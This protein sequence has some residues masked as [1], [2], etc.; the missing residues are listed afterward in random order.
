MPTFQLERTS[1]FCYLHLRWDY[2]RCK[3]ISGFALIPSPSLN[4]TIAI[5]IKRQ[6]AF[7][8]H[9][10]QTICYQRWDCSGKGLVQERASVERASSKSSTES[11]NERLI[12]M[13]PNVCHF[14]VSFFA[15]PQVQKSSKTWLYIQ[16][17]ADHPDHSFFDRL[18]N[19]KD[20]FFFFWIVPNAI[21]F[22]FILRWAFSGK[23][24][25][26]VS[27]FF[28]EGTLII[29]YIIITV[30][31]NNNLIQLNVLI[32]KCICKIYLRLKKI[33]QSRYTEE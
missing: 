29:I 30:Y 8:Q 26:F 7:C 11:F 15:L 17:M 32:M 6:P 22:Y 33:I 3:Q 12:Q 19:Q 24:I 20:W 31:Y 16:Q 21:L 23:W 25:H 5:S 9:I 14:G 4:K 2:H 27:C 13:L 28:P 18:V 10:S 1:S